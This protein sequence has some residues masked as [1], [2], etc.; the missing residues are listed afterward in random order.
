M[1]ETLLL[2]FL[3][4]KIISRGEI[5]NKIENSNCI[6]ISRIY[7]GIEMNFVLLA[8]IAWG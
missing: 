2:C 6:L 4:G 3:S 5:K 1:K 7:Y 8:L